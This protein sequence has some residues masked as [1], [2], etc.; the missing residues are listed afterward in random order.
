MVNEIAKTLLADANWGANFRL[1]IG[2]GM[3]VLDM[4]TDINMVFVYWNTPGQED[5]GNV[6]LAC[7]LLNI[8]WQLFVV[9]LQNKKAPLRV[10]LWEMI[11]VLSCTK[12]GVDAYR[13]AAGVEQETYNYFDPAFELGKKCLSVGTY[14][15]TF[16]AHH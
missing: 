16:R 3:S 6:L 14:I 1:G 7:L 12:V 2:A 13:V 11:Y 8:V 9:W 5:V 10:L 4:A 15:Y